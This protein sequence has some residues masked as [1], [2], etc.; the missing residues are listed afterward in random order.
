MVHAI[1]LSFIRCDHS[2]LH[3]RIINQKKKNLDSTQKLISLAD[4]REK[5]GISLRGLSEG[6]E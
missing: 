3:K 5:L 1:I 4:F 6:S 2:E